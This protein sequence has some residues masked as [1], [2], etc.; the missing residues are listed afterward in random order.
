[1]RNK[2]AQNFAGWEANL[3]KLAKEHRAIPS[4]ANNPPPQPYYYPYPGQ[5]QQP[6]SNYRSREATPDRSGNYHDARE[7]L[8]PTGA[9]RRDATTS[10]TETPRPAMRFEE[11]ERSAMSTQ[12]ASHR[13]YK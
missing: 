11:P 6:P 7:S 3:F 13:Q 12:G 8:N 4:F 9:R 1:M 2:T 10:N 5:L